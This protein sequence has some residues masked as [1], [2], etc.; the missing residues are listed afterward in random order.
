MNRG[1]YQDGWKPGH[2]GPQKVWNIRRG[3]GTRWCAWR[4]DTVLFECKP[5]PFVPIPP[6]DYAPWAPEEG[7]AD[8]SGFV[9]WLTGAKPGERFG[10]PDTH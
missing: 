9:R 1:G 6:E 4:T 3:L 2:I 5:G 8:A 7:A 10:G